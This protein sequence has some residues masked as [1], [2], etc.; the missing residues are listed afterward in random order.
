MNEWDCVDECY[1]GIVEVCL[2]VSLGAAVALFDMH[3]DKISSPS[4]SLY[5]C[6]CLSYYMSSCCHG[7]SSIQVG[8]VPAIILQ[9]TISTQSLSRVQ[10]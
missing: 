4:V 5:L 8:L 2:G 1:I 6:L 10:Y 7:D 3:F 9:Q